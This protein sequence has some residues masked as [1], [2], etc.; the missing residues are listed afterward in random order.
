MRRRR[1]A[2]PSTHPSRHLEGP[3]THRRDVP[4]APGG[5]SHSDPSATPLPPDIGVM[6][7]PCFTAS[8]NPVRFE[9][10]ELGLRP[11]D[12]EHRGGA[13]FVHFPDQTVHIVNMPVNAHRE[14]AR[15]PNDTARSVGMKRTPVP[16]RSPE[17]LE[18]HLVRGG[19][20]LHGN[21][22][23]R[24]QLQAVRRADEQCAVAT[25]GRM[26]TSRHDERR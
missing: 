18:G 21:D 19:A 26:S 7:V 16:A 3:D 13:L 6:L 14:N 17:H 20:R 11:E 2:P 8:A 1:S 22:T 24:G 5:T 9:D 25:T 10:V 4:C 15:F 12:R 23:Q